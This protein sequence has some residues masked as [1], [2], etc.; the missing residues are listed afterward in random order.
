ME[1]FAFI[2]LRKLAKNGCPLTQILDD[3]R[4]ELEWKRQDE[5]VPTQ[6]R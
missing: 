2:G 4:S 1:E 6:E 5:R 3:L